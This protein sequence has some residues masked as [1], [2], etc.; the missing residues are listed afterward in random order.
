[1]Y[2]SN[3]K[4]KVL[5]ELVGKVTVMKEEKNANYIIQN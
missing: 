4:N 3:K 1:M 2:L 5:Y